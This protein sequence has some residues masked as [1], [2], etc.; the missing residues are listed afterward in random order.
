MIDFPSSPSVGQVHTSGLVAWQ[1]DGEK[2]LAVTPIVMLL[3]KL[4]GNPAIA[5]GAGTAILYA[6][7][8]AAGTATLR[9]QAG[10]STTPIDLIVDVG[11]GF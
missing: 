7:Q 1:W 3:R 8:G 10:T 2:W 9:V 11:S 4:P 5:P 6:V